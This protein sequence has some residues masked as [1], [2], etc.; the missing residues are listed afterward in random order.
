MHEVRITVPK[1]LSS[2]IAKL[3]FNVGIDRVTVCP[4]VVLPDATRTWYLSD[5][6]P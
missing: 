4:V 6:S 5:V 2:G 1:G 3:A